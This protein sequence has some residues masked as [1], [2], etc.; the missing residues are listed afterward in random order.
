MNSAIVTPLAESPDAAVQDAA[1]AVTGLVKQFG[2]TKALGG[3][4]MRV[5]RGS[6]YALLGRNGAGKSTLIQVLMGM[7]DANQG[8]VDILGLNPA[9]DA[10]SLKKLIGY[11]PDRLPMYDWMTV[12]ELLKFVSAFYDRWSAADESELVS[13]FRIKRELKVG[14]LSRGN[15]ALLS[16]VVAMA[17]RPELVLLDECTSGMDA[18]ARREFERSVID[19]LQAGS[20]TVLFA[21]HQ[22]DEME[23]ICDWV[24]VM[25][26]GKMLVEMPLDDLKS[27]VRM[28]RLKSEAEPKDL[29]GCTIL[30]HRESGREHFVTVRYPGPDSPRPTLPA[31]VTLTEEVPLSLEEIFVALV[32]EEAEG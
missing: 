11:I 1:I 25:H 31:G 30:S 5:P 7:L 18:I 15:R 19:A 29:P 17:H 14:A 20:R 32:G 23:R 4:D 21:S 27:C 3:L 2:K 9:N 28:L 12:A 24:G 13:R 16:L 8:T 26:E 10:V 22:I 6:V